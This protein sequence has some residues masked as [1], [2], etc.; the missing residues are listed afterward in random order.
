MEN[1]NNKPIQTFREGA[2]GVSIWKRDG[3]QGEFF[4]FTLSRSYKK[5]ENE[6]G[7]AQTFREYNEQ[8]MLNVISQA[9]AFIR[10]Q[11]VIAESKAA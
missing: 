7:Y 1:E 9:A 8:A 11:G 5:N 10:Q 2:I 6:A 4:E 3:Q